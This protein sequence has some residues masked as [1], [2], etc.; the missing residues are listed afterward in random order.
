MSSGFATRVDSDRPAQLQ[1]LARGINFSDIQTRGIILQATV[2]ISKSR[3]PDKIL[4][5][6]SSLK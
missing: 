1:R 5:D 4:R 6:I 3:G 2:F